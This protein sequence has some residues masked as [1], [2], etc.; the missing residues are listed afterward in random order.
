MLVTKVQV[1]LVPS[2][3]KFGPKQKKLGPEEF[4]VMYHVWYANDNRVIRVEPA[5]WWHNEFG[6]T[7]AQFTPD[8]AQTVSMGLADL[9][10]RLQDVMTWLINAR[11][12][13]VRRNLRGRNIINP[14]FIDTK[15]LDGEGD[16]YMRKGPIRR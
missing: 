11:V 16:I 10:Y 6:W 13:D 4:P 12:T 14:A 5:Y 7:L 3:Y 8:M 2:K 1:W 15:T 9:I